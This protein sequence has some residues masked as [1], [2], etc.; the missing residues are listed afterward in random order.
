MY[1]EYVHQRVV[2]GSFWLIKRTSVFTS[3]CFKGNEDIHSYTD[4]CYQITKDVVCVCSFIRVFSSIND[5]FS[6][7]VFLLKISS[8]FF[9][10]ELFFLLLFFSNSFSLRRFFL[11]F[12]VKSVV[13]VDYF[14]KNLLDRVH[15]IVFL[16]F[17]LLLLV[18]KIGRFVYIPKDQEHV[19]P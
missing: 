4:P 1:P 16:M 5:V 2:F 10:I 9:P 17:L 11:C 3:T 13:D 6:S 15:Y 18:V 19:D 14:Y 12:H 7:V 8:G